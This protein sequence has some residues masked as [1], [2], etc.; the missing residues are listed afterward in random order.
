MVKEMLWHDV[1]ICMLCVKKKCKVMKTSE[2]KKSRLMTINKS[3]KEFMLLDN[4]RK[5][6]TQVAL[7][8][9]LHEFHR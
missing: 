9:G 3:C 2:S 6:I 5:Q 8:L 1:M 4:E 7:G